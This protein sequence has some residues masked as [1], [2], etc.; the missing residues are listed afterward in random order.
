MLTKLCSKCE[1]PKPLDAFSP[2]PKGVFKTHPWCKSCFA[3]YVRDRR[4]KEK[5]AAA[6][7]ASA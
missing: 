3:A 5:E 6:H 4:R 2:H 7:A 1:T